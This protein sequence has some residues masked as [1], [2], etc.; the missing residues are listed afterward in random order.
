MVRVIAIVALMIIISGC[1][2]GKEI[3][4]YEY[5]AFKSVAPRPISPLSEPGDMTEWMV[6][7]SRVY[8]TF[9]E[10]TESDKLKCDLILVDIL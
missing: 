2:T 9:G 4:Y 7:Y 6:K 1:C 10:L 3:A 5:A 8:C